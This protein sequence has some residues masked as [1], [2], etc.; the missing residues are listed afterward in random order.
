MTTTYIAHFTD[1]QT[2]PFA[3]NPF[4]VNGVRFPL[5]PKSTSSNLEFNATDARSSIPFYGKGVSNYGERIQENILQIL[6]NFAGSTAPEQPTIG[7]LWYDCRA[8]IHTSASPTAA[9]YRWNDATQ[10]WTDISGLI[11]V[12][13][14]ASTAVANT[15]TFQYTFFGGELYEG[16][17][18]VGHPLDKKW[19]KRTFTEDTTLG[20][21]NPTIHK[22]Q[23]FLRVYNG[24]DWLSVNDAWASSIE[25]SK[26][27]PGT[28]W[29]DT[30]DSALKV[31]NGT[32]WN[33]V[34][35]GDFLPRDGSLPMLASFN[36]G[37]FRVANVGTPT[38]STDAATKLYVDSLSLDSLTDVVISGATTSNVLRYNGSQWVNA[39]VQQSDVVGLVTAL[40]AINATL[41][42]KL[43]LAGGTM[44]GNI[45]MSSN[46]I[47]GLG[48][49]AANTDAATKVYVDARGVT[50]ATLVGSI[51]SL[52]GGP[53]VVP[54][55]VDLGSLP[56]NATSLPYSAQNGAVELLGN[57]PTPPTTA[58]S[59]IRNL[60]KIVRRRTTPRRSVFTGTSA[61][62]YTVPQY[63]IGSDKLFVYVDG[64]K[65]IASTRGRQSVNFTVPALVQQLDESILTGLNPASTYGCQITVNGTPFVITIAGTLLQNFLDVAEQINAAIGASGEAF[66]LDREIL[67]ISN[68]QGSGSSVSIV[69]G[70]PGATNLFSSLP[71][72]ASIGLAVAGVTH[73]YA[74]A[75]GNVGAVGSTITFTGAAGVVDGNTI[76][77]IVLGDTGVP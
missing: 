40:S 76:E 27:A 66:L 9:W 1:P 14:P 16:V 26:K 19:I 18:I 62:T 41:S 74:E 50:T 64:V 68:N 69:D 21:P 7:Q 60:D 57:L 15:P 42:T 28:L 67:V 2:A 10:T 63:E 71:Y 31:Y 13:N 11:Q 53:R 32:S 46:R 3:V 35:V 52:G 55:T 37:G 44:T 54:A 45:A 33:A 8:F 4:T 75:T 5:L 25:P 47:T 24:A 36:A 70:A 77:A 22:P 17:S 38:L 48:A 56:L 72:S 6:E 39:S 23:K 65:F 43:D 58:V 34:P 20:V 73:G 49:P 12:V 51:L 29:F 61:V 30:A 59:A